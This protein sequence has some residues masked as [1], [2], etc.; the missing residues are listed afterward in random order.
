MHKYIRHHQALHQSPPSKKEIQEIETIRTTLLKQFGQAYDNDYGWA[1]NVL[2]KNNPRFVDIERNAGLEHL[3]PFFQMASNNVHAG[4]KGIAIRLGDPP[5][6]Q[7]LLVAGPSIFGL[8]DPGRNTAH[9]L[10][11][12]T[13]TL[14]LSQTSLDNLAT[15]KA[16]FGLWHEVHESFDLAEVSINQNSS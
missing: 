12:L 13:T 14:L 1:A 2:G 3:R 5:Y 15:I 7:S 10:I 8:S 11:V 9:S 16:L 6:G 4:S